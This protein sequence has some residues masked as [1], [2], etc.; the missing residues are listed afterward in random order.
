MRL[1]LL[2]KFQAAYAVLAIG[3]LLLS[4]QQVQSGGVQFS[5][6]APLANIPIFL[7]YAGCLLLGVYRKHVPYRLAMLAAV[8]MFGGGGVV[9]N[10]VNYVQSGLDGY[11]SFAALAAAVAINAFGLIW[12]VIA[13]LGVYTR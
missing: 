3:Y 1:G 8:L 11:S 10:V 6:A 7:A 2:L 13:A 9:M 12:N 5:A 4:Y